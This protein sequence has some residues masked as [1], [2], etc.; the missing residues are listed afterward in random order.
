MPI[1]EHTNGLKITA[2][3]TSRVTVAVAFMK[4]LAVLS[5][6][7]PKPPYTQ[8]HI[9]RA[10]HITC[11]TNMYRTYIGTNVDIQHVQ[12]M[13]IKLSVLLNGKS[14][15]K[16]SKQVLHKTLKNGRYQFCFVF[17]DTGC[18]SFTQTDPLYGFLAH[19]YGQQHKPVNSDRH[20]G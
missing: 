17:T 6:A 19:I 5:K 13:S 11:K 14:I 2:L 18:V 10:K 7:L 12:Y 4:S 20:P 3:E 9:R 16:E 15:E 1:R 8:F